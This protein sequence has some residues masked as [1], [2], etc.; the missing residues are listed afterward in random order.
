MSH[1]GMF[2]QGVINNFSALSQHITAHL[3]L[4]QRIIMY[5]NSP[6]PCHELGSF[7]HFDITVL[8]RMDHVGSAVVFFSATQCCKR[9]N[10]ALTFFPT[11][12]VGPVNGRKPLSHNINGLLLLLLLLWWTSHQSGR[13]KIWSLTGSADLLVLS[14][15]SHQ[16]SSYKTWH[17]RHLSSKENGLKELRFQTSS[18]VMRTFSSSFPS[19]PYMK[20]V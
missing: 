4:L 10:M 12:F 3:E 15:Q 9:H 18:K 20:Q 6:P 19:C 5:P 11:S 1:T 14:L 7:Q 2:Q 8:V 16:V 13:W 17:H